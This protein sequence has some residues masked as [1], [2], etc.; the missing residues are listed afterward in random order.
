MWLADGHQLGSWGRLLTPEVFRTADAQPGAGAETPRQDFPWRLLTPEVFRTA[1][2]QPGAGARGQ[3][4]RRERDVPKDQPLHL[5]DGDN[6]CATT[7]ATAEPPSTRPQTRSIPSEEGM[8]IT[9][10]RQ[11]RAIMMQINT[12]TTQHSLTT[13]PVNQLTADRSYALTHLRTLRI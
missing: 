6:H 3:T 13:N 9:V 4:R 11:R 1:D 8:P 7:A 10:E 12:F 5:E 2:A